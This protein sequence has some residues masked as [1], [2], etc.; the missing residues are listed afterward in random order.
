VSG[1]NVRARYNI[2][3]CVL[4]AVNAV[5]AVSTA[6]IAHESLYSQRMLAYTYNARK[7]LVG[8]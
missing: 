6:S 3:S 5:S 4:C 7:R 2:G 8:I 1:V